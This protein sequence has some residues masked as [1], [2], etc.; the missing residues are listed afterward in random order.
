M[1]SEDILYFTY[2]EMMILENCGENSAT[3]IMKDIYRFKQYDIPQ[4]GMKLLKSDVAEFYGISIEDLM[5]VY[6]NNLSIR[7]GNEQNKQ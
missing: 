4:R 2:K 3:K 6:I 1:V 7:T 5:K